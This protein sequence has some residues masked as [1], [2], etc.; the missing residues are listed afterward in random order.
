MYV[1]LPLCMLGKNSLRSSAL[2]RQG[3][4][5]H[6]VAKNV[7]HLRVSLPHFTYVQCQ[8]SN[9]YGVYIQWYK[10]CVIVVVHRFC[11]WARQRCTPVSRFNIYIEGVKVTNCCCELGKGSLR[12]SALPR[13]ALATFKNWT[14]GLL[15][16]EPNSWYWCLTSPC[17]DRK[18]VVTRLSKGLLRTQS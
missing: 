7:V 13:Q 1:Q 9:V 15:P 12:S 8:D 5:T 10:V 16:K 4:A 2:P 14:V 11:P 6:T 17:L 3:L 18:V